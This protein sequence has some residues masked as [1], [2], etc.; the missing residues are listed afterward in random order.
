MLQQLTAATQRALGESPLESNSAYRTAIGV[1]GVA[2]PAALLLWTLGQSLQDSISAYY[3]TRGRNWFVGTLF[4][5]G[6]FLFF[7]QYKPRQRGQPKSP[8]P[9][10]RSGRAD[11]YLGKVAGVA[12]VCVALLPTEPPKGLGEPTVIGTLHG[13]S[14]FVLFAALSLFPLVLFSQST[15]KAGVYRSCGWV[16]VLCLALIGAYVFA[17]PESVQVALAPWKPVWV[18]ET[19]LI[20]GFGIS[21]FAKGWERDDAPTGGAFELERVGVAGAGYVSAPAS[22]ERR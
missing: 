2:L 10:I 11:A 9:V 3:Y 18:L 4:V 6:V 17:A 16:M 1:F 14:A 12:A 13:W 8:R 22:V 5:I 7:Y 19:V 15:K 20:L 21:W